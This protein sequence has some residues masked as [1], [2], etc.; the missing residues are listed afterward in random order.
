MLTYQGCVPAAL[1]RAI[2]S[3]CNSNTPGTSPR[4]ARTMA[5][6][7]SAGSGDP[8]VREPITGTHRQRHPGARKTSSTAAS[9]SALAVSEL[10]AQAPFVDFPGRRQRH[11]LDE[12]DL[13]RQPPI[14]HLAAQGPQ[15]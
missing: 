7:T 9:P 3:S 12:H 14:R 15:Q 1:R 13:I 2:T 6:P 11:S 10:G 8:S 4:E 5:P